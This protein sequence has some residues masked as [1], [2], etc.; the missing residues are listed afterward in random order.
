MTTEVLFRNHQGYGCLYLRIENYKKYTHHV[1][2]CGFVKT[3]FAILMYI[4]VHFGR[5]FCSR[6]KAQDK[7]SCP[8]FEL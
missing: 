7:L 8:H 3:S 2:N 4:I 1:S 5:S 6:V